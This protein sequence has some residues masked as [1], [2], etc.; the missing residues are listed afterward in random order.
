[1]KI[2][3][4]FNPSVDG[5]ERAAPVPGSAASVARGGGQAL[6]PGLRITSGSAKG[7]AW[8][9]IAQLCLSAMNPNR[10]DCQER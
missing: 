6:D 2:P 5:V 10:G 7:S 9:L 8:K 1:M 3:G 4:D